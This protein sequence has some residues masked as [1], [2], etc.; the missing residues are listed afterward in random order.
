MARTVLQ[1]QGE[2]IMVIEEPEVI[3]IRIDGVV[4]GTDPDAGSGLDH[5]EDEADES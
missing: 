1:V 4:G 2:G 3:D 5:D